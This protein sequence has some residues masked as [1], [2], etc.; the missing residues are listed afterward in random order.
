MYRG[1]LNESCLSSIVNRSC[2]LLIITTSLPSTPYMPVEPC[3]NALSDGRRGLSCGKVDLDHPANR[4][5]SQALA[6][7]NRIRNEHL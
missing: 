1:Q 4:Q 7:R 2:G 5:R 3:R 6:H